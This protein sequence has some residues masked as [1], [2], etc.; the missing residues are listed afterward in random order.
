M[1]IPNAKAQFSPQAYQ[2]GSDAIKANESRIQFWAEG[3]TFERGWK[4]IA[5]TSLGKPVVGNENSVAGAPDLDVLSLGDGGFAIVTF[6]HPIRNGAGPDFAVFE[7][8]FLHPT[9]STLAYLELAFVEVS[10][11]GVQ[12]F[13]FPAKSLTQDSAQ[14]DNFNW[15]DASKLNNLAGKYINGFGTPFDLE[16]LKDQLGLDVNNITHVKIIDVVG[17]LDETYASYDYDGHKINDP[18]PSA[19]PSGGFDLNAIGVLNSNATAISNIH[20]NLNAAIYPNPVKDKL[21]IEIKGEKETRYRI[22]DL[23]GKLYFKGKFQSHTELSIKN[24]A[25]G[26]YL[27]ELQND[28][29]SAWEKVIVE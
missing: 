3:C 18:Y 20:D 2:A 24:L 22:F 4:N 26:I 25:K 14:I 12:F 19:F 23:A 8:G 11:D 10:S 29:G 16:E 27:L 6:P 21:H 17:S 28:R 9:D 13:R 7:N 15:I 1:G 5:D